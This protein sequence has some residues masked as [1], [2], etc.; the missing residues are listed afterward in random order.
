MQPPYSCSS[1]PPARCWTCC[2]SCSFLSKARRNSASSFFR[3]CCRFSSLVR[4]ISQ[5]LGPLPSV[6]QFMEKRRSYL[7]T[8]CGCPQHESHGLENYL[9]RAARFSRER[10]AKRPYRL[11]RTS[12]HT[13]LP[14]PSY[15][16]EVSLDLLESRAY[17]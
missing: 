10:R 1:F 5:P 9:K 2:S 17:P 7:L 14:Y 12:L 13:T 16:I 11:H 15:A 6:L 3:S 8:A 4:P